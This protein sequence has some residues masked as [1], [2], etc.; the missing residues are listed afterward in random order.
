MSLNEQITEYSR[1]V[2][3]GTIPAAWRGIL[4]FMARLQRE[5][6][7]LFPDHRGGSLYQGMMDMSYFA[8]TPPALAA[9]RL[10]V[11]VVYRHGDNRFEVWLS[12][13]N[14]SV[15]ADWIAAFEAVNTAPWHRSSAAP[16]VDSI[17]EQVVCGEPDFDRP[18]EL[19][20]E[21]LAKLE[22][23]LIDLNRLVFER[24]HHEPRQPDL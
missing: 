19:I 20:R 23:D 18:E 5:T 7:W 2:R 11:A 24:R 14:R 12:G 3:A 16:G 22:A 6:G 15:Q 1:L 10:K 8:L 17:L 21:L 4:G 13:V 9:E